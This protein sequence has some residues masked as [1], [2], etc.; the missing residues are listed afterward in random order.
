MFLPMCKIC[1]EKN[2]IKQIK[3]KTNQWIYDNGTKVT[4]EE[5]RVEKQR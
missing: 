1:G 3:I 2:W 5:N 4:F